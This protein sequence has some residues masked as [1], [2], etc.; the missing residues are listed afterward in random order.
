MVANQ[1]VGAAENGGT[2]VFFLASAL[3]MRSF[4]FVEL[5]HFSLNIYFVS[6]RKVSK[7]LN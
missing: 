5:A 4:F 2:A 3:Y 6:T 1:A 7:M